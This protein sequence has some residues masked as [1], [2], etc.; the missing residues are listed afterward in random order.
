MNYNFVTQITFI[1]SLI[2]PCK[3]DFKFF[4]Q[5]CYINWLHNIN[6]TWKV[7]NNLKSWLLFKILKGCALILF[8]WFSFLCLALRPWEIVVAWRQSDKSCERHD[9]WVFV[10]R[11]NFPLVKLHLHPFGRFREALC[12]ITS[13]HAYMICWQKRLTMGRENVPHSGRLLLYIV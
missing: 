13:C 9:K 5:T 4:L 2:V 3:Y 10:L 6:T 1:S 12:E 11:R 7:L 8:L